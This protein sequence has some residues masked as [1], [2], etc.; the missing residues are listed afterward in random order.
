MNDL[1][2]IFIAFFLF[3]YAFFYILNNLANNKEKK[4]L[5]NKLH[6]N[7]YIHIHP[8][9]EKIY[10]KIK[11]NSLYV[12]VENFKR[13][14]EHSLIFSSIAFFIGLLTIFLQLENAFLLA[15]VLLLLYLVFLISVSL[16]LYNKYKIL[17]KSTVILPLVEEI[18]DKL[19]YTSDDGSP[20]EAAYKASTLESTAFNKY[21]SDD[22]MYG[23]IKGY[24]FNL[25][26]IHTQFVKSSDIGKMITH[27]FNGI[28]IYSYTNSNI[29]FDFKILNRKF[30]YAPP[31]FEVNI[32]NIEFT[33]NFRLYAEN[34]DAVIDVLND[35]IIELLNF[36][37]KTYGVPFDLSVN[38]NAFY[39]RFYTGTSFETP[40]FKK[41]NYLYTLNIYYCIMIFTIQFISTFQKYHK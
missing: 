20:T 38:Q 35:E 28:F 12:E 36:F 32:P 29:D 1:E 23:S 30:M 5:F 11:N 3:F 8:E 15:F 4:Y 33:K 2:S 22:Y 21:I 31:N 39:F 37:I 14:T 41:S 18:S 6:S 13:K 25:S 26:N 9:F 17:Y 27:L 19:K 16:P 10:N 34:R 24:N 7:T 40:L